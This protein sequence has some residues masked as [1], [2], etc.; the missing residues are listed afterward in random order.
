MQPS[1]HKRVALILC[2]VLA[3]EFAALAASRPHVC[4][5]ENLEQG[6]HNTPALL[7]TRLQEAVN[8]IEALDFPAPL[9]GIVLGYG[10][11][12][13][14][15]E[16][17]TTRRVPLVLP[18]AHD[19]ITLLLGSKERYAAYA[20]EHPGCYFYSPGWNRCHTPP[21]PERY[22]KLHKQY[23]EKCGEED[24]AFL[25]ESEQAWFSAYSLA[26]YVDTGLTPP[27]GVAKDIAYTRDCAAWLKWNFDHQQGSPRLLERLL[28]GPWNEDDFLVLEPGQIARMTAD[29]RVVTAVTLPNHT[30]HSTVAVPA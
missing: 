14:G 20:K 29:D 16:E 28:D 23:V 30:V 25:M 11:C 2:D 9:E 26:T 8:K 27:E 12:S 7:R 5:I 19:C 24:A 1:V 3:D 17:V 15:S 22:E 4:H 18:R 10:L 13:R 21:G 6:L